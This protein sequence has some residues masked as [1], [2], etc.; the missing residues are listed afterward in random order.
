MAKVKKNRPSS[1]IRRRNYCGFV[2]IGTGK[3]ISPT[4][5]VTGFNTNRSFGDYL[6]DETNHKD[7]DRKN[8]IR[9]KNRV[10][11]V[12]GK[13]MSKKYTDNHQRGK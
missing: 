1:R 12:R 10:G 7:I 4:G 2:G 9:Q 5:R 11:F 8:A 3:H 13:S 6:D